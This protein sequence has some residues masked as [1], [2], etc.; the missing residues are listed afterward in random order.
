MPG[1]PKFICNQENSRNL[2]KPAPAAE[3]VKL[4]LPSDILVALHLEVCK[5]NLFDGELCL[6]KGQCA[7][8]LAKLCNKLLMKH[9]LISFRNANITGQRMSMRA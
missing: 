9:F 8:A 7:D 3:D 6:Q 5:Q 1:I 2:D 4:W